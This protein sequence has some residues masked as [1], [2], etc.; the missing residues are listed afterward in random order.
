MGPGFMRLRFAAI[1]VLI[2]LGACV[3]PSIPIP[4]PDPALMRFELERDAN[5]AVTSASLIYPAHENYCGGV[6]YV[7]NKTLGE[8]I[9]ELV[10]SSCAIGPTRPVPA[11]LDDELVISI[12]NDEQTVSTCVR[13]GDGVASGSCL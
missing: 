7:F 6:V 5:G 13:L 9:I 1:A 3:T 11:R 10:K 12:E 2:G 8:G 4:P